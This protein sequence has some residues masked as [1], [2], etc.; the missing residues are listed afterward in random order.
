[1]CDRVNDTDFMRVKNLTLVF[2]GKCVIE[3]FSTESNYE[4]LVSFFTVEVG[5]NTI[6]LRV[7]MLRRM[8][9]FS[10]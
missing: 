1:M 6:A 4:V 7:Y 2:D 3:R 9:T 10:I 8:F 5:A